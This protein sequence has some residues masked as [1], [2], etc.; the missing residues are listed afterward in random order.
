MAYKD[1]EFDSYTYEINHKGS[2]EALEKNFHKLTFIELMDEK[3]NDLMEIDCVIFFKG[4]PLM[5][6]DVSNRN[7][8]KTKQF[9]F[10]TLYYFKHKTDRYADENYYKKLEEKGI[11][12][13]D[14]LKVWINF[15]KDKTMCEVIEFRKIL[16][17]QPK[18]N[19]GSFEDKVGNKKVYEIES[20]ECPTTITHFVE[21]EKLEELLVRLYQIHQLTV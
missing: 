15:S 7:N 21:V 4:Q 11:K 16:T 9:P 10:E 1:K 5:Y 18:I 2:I 13:G 14:L 19:K 8:W 3:G 12:Y 17:N 20:Y 6:A